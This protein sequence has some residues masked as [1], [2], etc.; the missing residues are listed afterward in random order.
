[1]SGHSSGSVAPANRAAEPLRSH[2]AGSGQVHSTG[3]ADQQHSRIRLVQDGAA[4][5]PDTLLDP[6]AVQVGVS[7]PISPMSPA[8]AGVDDIHDAGTT[9][10]VSAAPVTRRHNFV[11]S[12]RRYVCSLAVADAFVG[13]IAA[14]APTIFSRSIGGDLSTTVLLAII[15]A[16]VWPAAI[17]LA[18]GY[19]RNRIGVGADEV[20]AVL[21][22]GMWVVVAGAFPAGLM[23]GQT[24]LKLVVTAVPLAVIL[25][26]VARFTARKVLHHRQSS[27]LSVRQVIVVGSAAA[28]AELTARLNRETHCGM[29]V[30]GACVPRAE[31]DQA[32]DHGLRVVGDLSTVASVVKLHDCDAVAVTSDD[33]TRNT[34]LREL[35]WSLE[36]TGIEMLVDPG[37]VEVAGPRLH[38]RPV[39][40]APLVH[41]EQPR[42]TGWRRAVKRGSDVVLAGLLLAIGFIPML[43]ISLLVKF[44]DGGAI[45]FAQ[46]RVGR[47]GKPF[48][49]FKFRS[50]VADAEDRKADLLDQNE[51]DGALFKMKADPRV[52]RLGK[53]LRAYSLDELPQLINV[54]NGTMSLVGPRP[55]LAHEV[56]QMPYAAR[57]ALVTPGVTGLWQVE[58]RSELSGEDGIRLDLR[59]VENWTLTMDLLILWKTASAVLYRRGSY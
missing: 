53:F 52:T 43:V 2:S 1:M 21:R 5:A 11:K 50:M 8:Y 39:M 46:Q 3:I 27:G 30:I 56:A 40:G 14:T 54:L 45:L 57:R 29:K 31:F 13:A 24:Y 42:F 17:G 34:Y 41:I 19:V 10:T 25:S 48:T 58:G 12:S 9:G 33:S 55:H 59:Y 28:T 18:R 47:G 22:A 37:L 36:G 32:H 49:M 51:S 23:D 7:H 26:T 44:Q 15:G 20:R 16:L 38:I 35:A 4:T 6:P